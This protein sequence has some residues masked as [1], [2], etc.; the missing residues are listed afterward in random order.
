MDCL[1]RMGMP[2][3]NLVVIRSSNIEKLGAFYSAI[4]LEFERHQH[5]SGPEHLAAELG[6]AVFEIYPS[7][8]GIEP[9]TAVRLGFGVSSVDDMVSELRR[10]GAR[11]LREPA[12]SP[13]GRRA[14]VQDFEGHK[15]ELT[16]AVA[17]PG[18]D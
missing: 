4:G 7:E 16:E 18:T 8:R 17:K 10:M 5:G 11:V 2:L 14:V 9:T 15:V 1:I 13:W 6:G 12:A 3:L